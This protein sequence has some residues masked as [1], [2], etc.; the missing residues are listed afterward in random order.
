MR[1]ARNSLVRTSL[2]NA[3]SSH[4]LPSPADRRSAPG[5]L[6]LLRGFTLVE[7]VL[8]ASLM[9]VILVSA[10][11]CL[12]AAFSS[13]KMIEPRIEALQSARVALALMAADFRC[14]CPLSKDVEFLGTQHLLG[15]TPADDVTFAT[16]NYTPRRA[17]EGDF[18][19][20]SFFLQRNQETGEI[21]LWRKRN[22]TIAP[23]PLLGG[24]R[25]EELARGV[26]GLKLEYSDGLDWY[27]SWGEIKGKAKQESSLKYHPNLSGMPDAVRI[28][29][30]LD[31]NPKAKKPEG[32]ESTSTPT[33]VTNE[34]PLV[35]QTVARL[36]LTPSTLTGSSSTSSTSSDTGSQ[37][38]PNGGQSQ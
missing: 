7:L 21:S 9:S 14:A 24:G 3:S 6:Q 1:L 25:S 35:F 22:P 19:E 15:E 32:R 29:L 17:N 20:V 11:L 26:Q 8:S 12:Q 23:A 4:R 5:N 18:C 30:W 13:Q 10:Y 37:P 36:N 28:T 38:T 27:D 34:P 31:P 2:R 33:V 16:H